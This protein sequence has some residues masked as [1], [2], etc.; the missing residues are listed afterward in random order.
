MTGDA[1]YEKK[2]GSTSFARYSTTAP[3][4]DSPYVSPLASLKA[5]KH[6][7]QKPTLSDIAVSSGEKVTHEKFG[8]GTIVDVKGNVVTVIFDEFGT[9]KLAK[10]LAPLKKVED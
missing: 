7:T 8:K 6:L 4:S 3:Y 10:D 5:T 1:I 9:K 2:A